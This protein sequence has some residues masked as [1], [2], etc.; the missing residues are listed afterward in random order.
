MMIIF[1]FHHKYS[2][3]C[4]RLKAAFLQQ[5]LTPTEYE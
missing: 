3:C 2:I 1:S 5:N 4:I